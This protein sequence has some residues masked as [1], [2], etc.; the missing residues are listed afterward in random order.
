MAEFNRDDLLKVAKLSALQLSEQ[1]IE[2]FEQ[3]LKK[4]LAFVDQITAVKVD[5]VGHQ[6][7]NV[8]ILRQDEAIPSNSED[9]IKISPKN[10][11]NYF[12]VPKILGEKKETEC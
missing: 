8:N 9:I 5:N 12:V 6:V 11:L 7:R 2:S 1:E 4:V 10:Q 3:Q